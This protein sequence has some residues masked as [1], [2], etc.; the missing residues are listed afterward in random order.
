MV[1]GSRTGAAAILGRDLW[2]S[3]QFADI[4]AAIADGLTADGPPDYSRRLGARDIRGCDRCRLARL[5]LQSF[6]EPSTRSR[7]RLLSQSNVALGEWSRDGASITDYDLARDP[8]PIR[9]AAAAA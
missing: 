4:H 1:A 5:W 9:I 8:R 3:R 2:R 7:M 6:R